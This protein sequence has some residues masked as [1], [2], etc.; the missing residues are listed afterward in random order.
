MVYQ[1]CATFG[2][3]PGP[4]PPLFWY[5]SAHDRSPPGARPSALCY[6]TTLRKAT[7]DGKVSPKQAFLV[8]SLSPFP[9]SPR[10][11]EE[12]KFPCCRHRGRARPGLRAVICSN[13]PPEKQLPKKRP[14]TRIQYTGTHISLFLDF[15]E[16]GSYLSVP[17]FTSALE[18]VLRL[19][20]RRQSL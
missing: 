12:S 19:G 6:Y 16:S 14:S 7:A 11:P 4:Q 13:F 20:N 8:L 15:A 10:P 2:Y 3:I 18:S 9:P 1:Y 17:I 5:F